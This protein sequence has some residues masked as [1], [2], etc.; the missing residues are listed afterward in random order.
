ME[1]VVLLKMTYKRF[2]LTVYILNLPRVVYSPKLEA[3]IFFEQFVSCTKNFIL[4][5]ECYFLNT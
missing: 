3:I 4:E 2:G 5:K 1:A